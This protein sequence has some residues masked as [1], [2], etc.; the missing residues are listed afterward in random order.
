MG[1]EIAR[2][3]NKSELIP[4]TLLNRIKIMK[5]NVVDI[6]QVLIGPFYQ[7]ILQYKNAVVLSPSR[8]RGNPDL[9]I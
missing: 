6:S 4:A 5:K 9:M 7:S 3:K 1:D 8:N 2:K